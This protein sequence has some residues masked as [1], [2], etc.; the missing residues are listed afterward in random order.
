VRFV[1]A[2]VLFVVAFLAIGYGLAQRT[3]LIG[4]ASVTQNVTVDGSAP[5]TLVKPSGLH[6]YP[7]TQT[8]TVS[9][10]K[11]VFLAAGRSGD[12]RAWIGKAGYNEVG[13]SAKKEAFTQRTVAG[14]EKSTPSPAGSDLWIQEF[15]GQDEMTRKINAPDDVALLIAADGKA[16]AP[17]KLSISWPLD[18]S[19]PFATPLVIGGIGALLLGLLMLLWALIHTRR[20]RGPRR[21]TPKLPR[22]PRPPQLKRGKEPKAIEAPQRGRRRSA[23]L[24]FAGI[25]AAALLLS[26]CT[27]GT[28]VAT[29]S[30]S[31][32]P[33]G[34]EN[35]PKPVVTEPQLSDILAHAER[36]VND[37][38]AKGDATLLATRMDGPAL[39]LRTAN[40]QLRAADGNQPAVEPLPTGKV[41][42]ALP[43]QSDDW[44]RAVFAVIQSASDEK[45]APVGVMLVQK[46]PRDNYKIVYATTLELDVP[47]VAP[48]TVGSARQPGDNKIGILR[49]D[50]LAAAYG[51]TLLN[52]DKSK[53][54]KDFQTDGDK[55]AAAIGPAYK[56]DK[57]AKLPP[58]ATIEYA[59]QP[60][61]GEVIA[62]GT[63]DSGQIV[64]VSANETET[65]KPSEAG[66]AI[67]PEGA[68]KALSGKSQT[69]K[70]IT[71]TYG[72]QLLF[73]VPPV[74]EKDKKIQLLGFAQGL[75]SAAEVP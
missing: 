41:S 7:G 75:V 6:A 13:W 20:R 4:P 21:K 47:A 30:A 23:A 14:S 26:G 68:V 70:G 12:V 33:V 57:K 3:I 2:I 39:Q 28:P 18:N 8:I 56:A 50:Q 34:T 52:G 69:L 32:T 5:L 27:M 15:T 29:P 53:Y 51:D 10:G 54:A 46:A 55:L 63:N 59:D 65:V 45:A 49:P 37:A 66:A 62:F 22:N 9:G 58:T 42:I 19:T 60:G 64:A 31:S 72:L 11:T 35:L 73:Y 48:A 25:T 36:T 71:A 44:P 74:T 38:D 17:S 67:N 43:Q 16:A 40:Y 24:G 61:D 1:I